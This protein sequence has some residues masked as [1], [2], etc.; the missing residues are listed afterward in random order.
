MP[1]RAGCHAHRLRAMRST[2]PHHKHQRWGINNFN[3][4]HNVPLAQPF[5]ISNPVRQR[6]NLHSK[7][8]DV[9]VFET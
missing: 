5:C 4:T 3:K 8:G 7:V 9:C 6:R 1:S 2:I